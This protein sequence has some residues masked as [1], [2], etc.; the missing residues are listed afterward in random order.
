MPEQ[1]IEKMDEAMLYFA[2]ESLGGQ[3][4]LINHSLVNGR[5]KEDLSLGVALKKMREI[6]H[7][8]VKRLPEFGVN[9]L[10][11]DKPTGEYWEWY[12]RWK[13][14]HKN[15][16]S[17]D[18]WDKVQNAISAAQED[19]TYHLPEWVKPDAVWVI[20]SPPGPSKA[21]AAPDAHKTRCSASGEHT[22]TARTVGALYPRGTPCQEPYPWG[23]DVS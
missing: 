10:E 4:W 16:L 17:D 19:G 15:E 13:H 2:I 14:W 8:A 18:K 5:M 23:L 22:A 20:H 3:I 6:Q 12:R 9:S 1:N 7:A 21:H 11:N